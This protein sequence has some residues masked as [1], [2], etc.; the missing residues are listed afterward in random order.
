MYC[1]AP[2]E[3]TP[4]V[5][6]QA[7]VTVEPAAVITGR[8]AAH[9]DW[10]PE[11]A[12]PTV[13]AALPRYRASRV[14]LTWQQRELDPDQVRVH[15][16]LRVTSRPLTVLDLIPDLGGQ[17]I[18]EAL[19]RGAVT[20]TQLERLFASMPRRP[21][22]TLRSELLRDSKDEPWSEA[23]RAFHRILRTLELPCSYATNH[24]LRLSAT[25]KRFFDVA[26]RDLL[27]AFEVDGYEFHSDRAA[28]ERDRRNDA[29]ARALGWDVT[30]FSAAQVLNDAAEVADVVS[31]IVAARL[32]L[33]RG[34]RSA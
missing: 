19:R 17:V 4:L 1:T 24:P 15:G 27:L 11:L 26:L 21:G 14:G 3:I 33:F 18:D 32:A 7:I 5:S 12:V 2:T 10:W 31:R 22:D 30:R 20:L 34:L 25:Q 6:A 28:F 29:A 13:T 8:A 23:E 9:L 16:G